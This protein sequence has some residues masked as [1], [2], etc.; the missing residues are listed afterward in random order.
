MDCGIS[1]QVPG[2]V[3]ACGEHL[4]IPSLDSSC[5]SQCRYAVHNGVP[6]RTSQRVAAIVAVLLTTAPLTSAAV[7]VT[8]GNAQ[9]IA[10]NDAVAGSGY[11]GDAQ[12]LPKKVGSLE[13]AGG[14]GTPI[15]AT[16]CTGT[17]GV[18][19]VRVTNHL[20]GRAY[21]LSLRTTCDARDAALPVGGRAGDPYR[22]AAV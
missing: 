14:I 13:P 12:Q 21:V 18:V 2:L 19:H 8:N 3:S 6:L 7:V 20:E 22:N 1:V 11:G 5:D 15:A 17:G 4:K 10:L 16:D 9:T